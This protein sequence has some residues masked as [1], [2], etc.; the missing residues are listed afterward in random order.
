MEATATGEI[1]HGEIPSCTAYVVKHTGAY[2]HLGNAWAA[3]IMHG[4]AKEFVTDKTVPMFEI[5]ENDPEETPESK[6]VTYVH[7]PAK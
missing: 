5:Y 6:L 1:I 3:G 4:R 7:I 2:R